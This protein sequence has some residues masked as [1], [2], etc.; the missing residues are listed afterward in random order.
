MLKA[1]AYA[2]CQ[3]LRCVVTSLAAERSP[4]LAGIHL[5]TLIPFPV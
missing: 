3:K 2:V 4:P 1:L 5:D